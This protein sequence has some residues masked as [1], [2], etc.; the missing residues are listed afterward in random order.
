[1]EWLKR[2]IYWSWTGFVVVTACVGIYADFL[3]VRSHSGDD[4]PVRAMIT[5]GL[6]YLSIVG[7]PLGVSY[8]IYQWV[9]IWLDLR[10]DG[11]SVR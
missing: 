6:Y 2:F 11:P 10:R 5:T 1:M 8:L 9:K 7:I 3:E 4:L